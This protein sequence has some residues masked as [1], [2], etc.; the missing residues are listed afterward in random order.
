VDLV[1]IRHLASL[2]HPDGHG[3]VSERR[4]SQRARSLRAVHTPLQLTGELRR[5]I[6]NKR[7]AGATDRAP[8]ARGVIE[9]MRREG[10]PPVIK[11]TGTVGRMLENDRHVR[12]LLLHFTKAFDMVDHFLLLKNYILF[13]WNSDK[14]KRIHSLTMKRNE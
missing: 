7:A 6:R 11:I 9:R 8:Q 10:A 5:Q 12:R 14:V 13:I 3:R 2:Y 4:S 1:Q